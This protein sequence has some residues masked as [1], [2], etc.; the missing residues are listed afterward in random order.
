MEAH[1]RG[2]DET[3]APAG[4]PR[5]IGQRLRITPPAYTGLP[6]RDAAL[7]ARA[8]VGSRLA[9]ALRFAPNP[10][11]GQAPGPCIFSIIKYKRERWRFVGVTHEVHHPKATSIG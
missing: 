11:K 1:R 6:A 4:P 7:S 2:A 3:I 10:T 9:F 8:P 5:L